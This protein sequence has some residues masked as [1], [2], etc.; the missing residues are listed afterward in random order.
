MGFFSHCWCS[1]PTTKQL[2]CIVKLS[3]YSIMEYPEYYP[4][5]FTATI[6]EW[7]P[8]LQL[9]VCKEIIINSLKFLSTENKITVFGFVIM[10]NHLHVI[11][12]ISNHIDKIKLQQS[13]K[14]YTAQMMLKELRNNHVEKLKMFQVNAADRK[15]QVWERNSLSI[16]I[17]SNEVMFQK[18]NYIHQN[19]VRAGIIELAENYLYS[20]ASLYIKEEVIWDFV[21]KWK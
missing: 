16:E 17:R 9:T 10:P 19:P 13:F 5:F 14:K 8:L 1:S 2:N 15:Y 7:K 4:D 20:S 11:W 12:Q 6:L 18:L 21:S 3:L